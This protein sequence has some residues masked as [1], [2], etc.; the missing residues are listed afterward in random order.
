MVKPHSVFARWKVKTNNAWVLSLV[1][2]PTSVTIPDT[3]P[4]K[5]RLLWFWGDNLTVPASPASERMLS[6]LQSFLVAAERRL[7]TPVKWVMK[8]IEVVKK[9]D[10]KGVALRW[11]TDHASLS[12]ACN[13]R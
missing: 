4:L 3:V 5:E 6:S 1:E 12:Y 2:E 13:V 7:S 10:W 9:I 11:R 8:R